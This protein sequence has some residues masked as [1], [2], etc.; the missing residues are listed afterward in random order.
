MSLSFRFLTAYR[1]AGGGL[2]RRIGEWNLGQGLVEAQQYV[3]GDVHF[4][5][6]VDYRTARKDQVGGA[7]GGDFGDDSTQPVLHLLKA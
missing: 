1:T 4:V 2:H 3:L 6:H 5:A 7:L